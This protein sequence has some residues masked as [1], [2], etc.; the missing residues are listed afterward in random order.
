M[1]KHFFMFL[2]A[3]AALTA[4]WA[5]GG[6]E[7]SASDKDFVFTIGLP[8]EGGLCEAPFYIAL[9]QKLLKPKA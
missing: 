4:V 5:G 3:C 6:K 2:L 8:V 1:K 9:E 7:K